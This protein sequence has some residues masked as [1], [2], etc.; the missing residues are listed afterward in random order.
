LSSSAL[1]QAQA[2][3][4]QGDRRRSIASISPPPL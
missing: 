3:I 4:N 1:A 2:E